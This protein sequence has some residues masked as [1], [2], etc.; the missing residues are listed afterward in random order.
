MCGARLNPEMSV[1][2]DHIFAWLSVRPEVYGVSLHATEHN[3]N[4]WA[5]KNDD[6]NKENS[7][8]WKKNSNTIGVTKA[9]LAVRMPAAA[10]AIP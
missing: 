8:L 6:R 10:A 1:T 4:S 9:T 2:N 3:P 7:D 5:S